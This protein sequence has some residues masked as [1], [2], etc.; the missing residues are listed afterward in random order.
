MA[1]LCRTLIQWCWGV[2]LLSMVVGAIFR[3][4]PIL[5]KKTTLSGR[6]GVILAGV[7]FLCALATREL[8]RTLTPGS[9]TG[10]PVQ[11]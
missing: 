4:A 10:S 2:G 9:Q 1:R 11:S 6:G 5:E 7:L 3:L 8:E